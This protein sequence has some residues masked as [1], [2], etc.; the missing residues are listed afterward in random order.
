MNQLFIQHKSEFEQ[1]LNRFT[2]DI[3][4]LRVGR[5]SPAMV[6]NL[7]IEVYGSKMPLIQLATINSTGSSELVIQPWDKNNL[8]PI[9]K[10]INESDLGFSVVPQENA[11]RLN[12]PQLTEERRQEIIKILG[13]KIEKGRIAVRTIRDKVR[14]KIVKMERSREIGEDEKYQLQDE[15]DK[16]TRE[17][18]DKIEEVGE[19][20]GKEIRRV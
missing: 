14:E 7:L 15:L 8:K 6:E 5:A 10:A 2:Q 18:I 9:E 13:E 20:K 17:Y 1:A 19:R 3:S 16:V 11:V 12:L 4:T